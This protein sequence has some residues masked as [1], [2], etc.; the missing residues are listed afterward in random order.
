[1]KND[2]T[3]AWQRD[4]Y[5]TYKTTG[6]PTNSLN[7]KVKPEV[8]A[9]MEI[10]SSR[11]SSN[12]LDT[13]LVA[14]KEEYSQDS[15]IGSQYSKSSV[16]PMKSAQSISALL[17]DPLPLMPSLLSGLADF[18]SIKSE[19]EQ[20]HY[21][22]PDSQESR[23]QIVTTDDKDVLSTVDISALC[24]P[25][26]TIPE[27]ASPPEV[28]PP[29]ITEVTTVIVDGEKKSEHHKSEKKRKKKE[30]HSRKD[31]DKEKK[32]KHKHKEKEKDKEKHIKITIQ[33]DKV[34]LSMDT[35][36]TASANGVEKKPSL[37]AIVGLKIKIPKERLK[38]SETQSQAPLKLKIRTSGSGVGNSGETSVS[39][40][41]SRKRERNDTGAEVQPNKKPRINFDPTL[42]NANL[43]HQ[44]QKQNGHYSSNNKVRT[45][46]F[47][48]RQRYEDFANR[49]QRGLS[50]GNQRHDLDFT[51]NERS[52]A[53]RF[54]GGNDNVSSAGIKSRQFDGM[55]AGNMG[56][57]IGRNG[58]V[59]GGIAHIFF[60]NYPPPNFFGQGYGIYD[61]GLYY[62]YQQRENR[63]GDLWGKLCCDKLIL[64][65]HHRTLWGFM[66]VGNLRGIYR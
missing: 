59:G 15:G 5:E 3:S 6:Q 49:G 43:A 17:Q 45:G 38:V 11:Q 22:Y 12:G 26:R 60:A 21:S 2:E 62:Q 7:G 33:K 47:N 44:H 9:P 10:E 28:P 29:T 19:S 31:K 4:S 63:H 37:M 8:I 30:K 24:A 52:G 65:F 13:N 57:G 39:V 50:M 16:S 54:V 23:T 61:P 20:K 18:P 64:L 48:D 58:G 1:M 14:K 66:A 46:G 56:A 41:M 34:N 53:E 36:A 51:M 32:K 35:N 27:I 40:S 42:P 25:A 55:F